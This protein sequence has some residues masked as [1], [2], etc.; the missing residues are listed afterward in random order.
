M[1]ADGPR[2]AATARKT[3]SLA[4]TVGLA[5][6]SDDCRGQVVPAGRGKVRWWTAVWDPKGQPLTGLFR[7]EA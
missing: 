2:E 6:L 5:V 4:F 7:L 1:N 3:H